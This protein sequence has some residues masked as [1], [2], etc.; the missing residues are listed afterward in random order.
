[1]VKTFFRIQCVPKQLRSSFYF[2]EREKERESARERKGST[3][4]GRKEERETEDWARKDG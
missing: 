4:E 2:T 3:D 1:M